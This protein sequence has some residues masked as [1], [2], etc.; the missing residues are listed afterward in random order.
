MENEKIHKTY[1][2][3]ITEWTEMFEPLISFLPSETDTISDKDKIILMHKAYKAICNYL[4]YNIEIYNCIEALTELT[5]VYI[6]LDMK[7]KKALAGKTDITQ[8]SQG[9]RSITYSKNTISIDK[10]GINEV[11]KAMLPLPKMKVW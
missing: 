9:S 1:N 2:D 4:N 10:N 7:D 5:K 3:Y 11:V 8:Q 6:Y